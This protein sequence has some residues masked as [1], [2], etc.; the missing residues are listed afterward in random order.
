MPSPIQGKFY[1]TQGYGLTSFALS[2]AG[3][4]AYKNFPGG[5]HAGLDFGTN[6]LPLPVTSI[7]W[8]KVV[9]AK[10]DGGWGNHVEVQG[11]DGWRRQYAHLS[12]IDVREGQ[13]VDEGTVLGLVG[14][15]GA[16]SGVHLHL[17]CRKA[18][19]VGWEY[20]DPS[21]EVGRAPR[22]KMPKKKLI[23]A[24]G[25]G[26]IY[27]WT[28]THKH[29]VPDMATLTFYFPEPDIELVDEALLTKLPEGPALPPV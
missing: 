11:D 18:K 16:S 1:L 27:V 19:L 21:E 14:T 25:R 8:G 7:C 23:K 3:K 2:P 15:T 24:E 13:I 28:G 5:I 6:Q 4:A 17:G 29:H 12:R 10:M 22:A 20:R 9:K 26:E